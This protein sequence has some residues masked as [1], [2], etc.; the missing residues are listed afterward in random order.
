MLSDDQLLEFAKNYRCSHP[1]CAPWLDMTE[2]QFV[3][4]A[5][6]IWQASRRAALEEAASI[7]DAEAENAR[8]ERYYPGVVGAFEECAAAIPALAAGDKA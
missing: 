2:D 5:R 6:A 7:V 4:V 8:Q 3:N 1:G